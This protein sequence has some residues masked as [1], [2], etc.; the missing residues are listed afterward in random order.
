MLP[1]RANHTF[2]PRAE[3]NNIDCDLADLTRPPRSWGSGR[4]SPFSQLPQS[5]A[6]ILHQAFRY[7]VSTRTHRHHYERGASG[8]SCETPQ[9]DHYPRFDLLPRGGWASQEDLQALHYIQT[10]LDP[11]THPPLASSAS[12]LEARWARLGDGQ[13]SVFFRRQQSRD[14]SNTFRHQ[15]TA[16]ASEKNSPSAYPRTTTR[17]H[18]PETHMAQTTHTPAYAFFQ[19][20]IADDRNSLQ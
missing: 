18:R 11:G 20:N 5:I 8:V 17:K 9:R 7:P 4:L 6:Y 3:S 2:R 19:N 13:T 14:R 10:E 16:S 15:L 1:Q 12:G